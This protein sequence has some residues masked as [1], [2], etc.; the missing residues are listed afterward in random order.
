AQRKAYGNQL[1]SYHPLFWSSKLHFFIESVPFYNFPYTFGYLFSLSL[2]A[3]FQENPEGF[4][5]K[6]IALLR[7]TGS[8]KVEDLAAK[9]L[10]VDMRDE[11]FWNKGI[12]LM[13]A[14]VEEFLHLTEAYL[15]KKVSERTFRNIYSKCL[16]TMFS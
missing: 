12:D 3:A 13:I 9:H 15:K 11:A 16:F 1:S 8:M 7:D 4:E 2:Y 6:Y 10:K 14:D 5:E